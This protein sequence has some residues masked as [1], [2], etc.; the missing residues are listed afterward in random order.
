MRKICSPSGIYK[1]NSLE[2]DIKNFSET[3]IERTVSY[4]KII[5]GLILPKY[6]TG[7]FKEVTFDFVTGDISID[8]FF[9]D[10]DTTQN[11]NWDTFNKYNI[12][13]SF[14]S[15]TETYIKAYYNCIVKSLI[16]VIDDE[17][18][19]N[20]ITFTLPLKNINGDSNFAVFDNIAEVNIKTAA[21]LLKV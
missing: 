9:N 14:N 8:N 12:I 21:M 16:T 6:E 20:K 7:I 5:G 11:D 1:L 19:I 17:I 13:I 15:D 18:V 2:S 10:D 4:T 3:V